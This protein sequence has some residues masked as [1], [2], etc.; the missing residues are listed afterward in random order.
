MGWLSTLFTSQTVVEK[1]VDGL[2]NGID[3]AFYT[4]EEKEGDAQKR[5]DLFMKLLPLTQDA[6]PA[7][8]SIA[9]IIMIFWLIVG[10]DILFLINL[11][12][13]F[14]SQKE[15]FGD[16]IKA[17]L[18]FAESYVLTPTSI[19]LGFYFLTQVTKPF[20]PAKGDKK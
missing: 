20:A 18:T 5:T 12:I 8:R 10:V 16:A 3:K 1:A 15:L 7:R 19:V 4:A 2:Y 13:W 14:P 9:M 6:S 11:S 17:I